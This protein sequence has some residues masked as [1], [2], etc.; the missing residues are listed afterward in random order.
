MPVT[1][2]HAEILHRAHHFA[3]EFADAKYELGEAQ[4]F[5]RGLCDVFSFSN[6]QVNL[7]KQAEQIKPTAQKRLRLLVASWASLTWRYGHNT[8]RHVRP[9]KLP[10]RAA[11][12]R[13]P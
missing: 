10:T 11:N 4:N 6:Q 2:N 7:V 5:I 12:A 13:L 3:K 9:R 8:P 1:L